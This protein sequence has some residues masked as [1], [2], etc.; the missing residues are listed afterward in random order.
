MP[1]KR[2]NKRF[3]SFGDYYAASENP[4]ISYIG[5]LGHK[6]DFQKGA[7]G[8]LS[9][10]R[11]LIR[12]LIHHVRELDHGV[13]YPYLVF[14]KQQA[15]DHVVRRIQVADDLVVLQA[16]LLICNLFVQTYQPLFTLIIMFALMHC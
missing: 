4:T 11:Y 13:P 3:P 8:F 16:S 2:L 10:Y 5:W 15:L 9:G 1:G 6:D 12:N 7:G 14:N